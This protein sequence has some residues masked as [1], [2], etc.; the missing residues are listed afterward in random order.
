MLIDG[1]EMYNLMERLFPICRSITGKGNRETLHI[2]NEIIS[3]NIEE[4]PS[5]KKVYDWTVPDEWNINN[6]WIK[7]ANGKKI[8]D[9]NKSNLPT[10]LDVWIEEAI[11]ND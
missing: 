5:G 6:A 1:G 9:F 2:L 4:V 11:E 3:I 8:I 7:G 10:P